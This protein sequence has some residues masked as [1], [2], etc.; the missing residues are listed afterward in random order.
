MNWFGGKDISPIERRRK[1]L[2][3]PKC[4]GSDVW[5]VP[6]DVGWFAGYMGLQDKKPFECRACLHR[7]YFHA[8]RKED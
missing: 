3:C 7:F 5:R 4:T 6:A 1:R 8:R 2:R